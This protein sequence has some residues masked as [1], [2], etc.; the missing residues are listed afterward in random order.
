MKTNHRKV[1]LAASLP[2][3]GD[4]GEYRSQK[5]VAGCFAS[6]P[7]RLTIDKEDDPLDKESRWRWR[8]SNAKG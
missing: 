5:G 6:G 8:C 3:L 2:M 7:G 4:T 1:Y